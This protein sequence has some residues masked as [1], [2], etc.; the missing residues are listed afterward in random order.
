VARHDWFRN[1]IWNADIEADFRQRLRRARDKSQYLRIQASHLANTHPNVALNLLDQYFALGDHFDFAQA[2][3]DKGRAMR[4]L[5]DIQGALTSYEAALERERHH[6]SYTTQAYLD[7]ACL[8][9]EL[10]IE[11]RYLQALEVLG[12]HRDRPAFPVEHYRANGA[13][14]LLLQHFGR[15]HEARAAAGL[16]IAAAHEVGSGFRYHRNLGLVHGI[17]DAFGKRIAAL[18]E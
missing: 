6:P 5:G 3:V 2:H 9:A 10:Q 17:E 15:Q 13:R 11:A 18:A 12:A 4:A 16:A 14:A 1:T 7:F 8:V